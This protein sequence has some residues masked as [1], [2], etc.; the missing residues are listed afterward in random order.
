MEADTRSKKLGDVD[1]TIL[2]R[3]SCQSEGP[4]KGKIR[5]MARYVSAQRKTRGRA[6]EGR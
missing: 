5:F 2:E 3:Q 4:V 1:M 6:S